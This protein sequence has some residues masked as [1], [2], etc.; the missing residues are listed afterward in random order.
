MTVFDVCFVGLKCYDLISGAP[1]Q[2]F[3]GGA[4]KQIVSLARG[5]VT[6]GHR[7]TFVTY[8]H[9]QRDADEY[10]GIRVFKS[11]EPNIGVPGVRFVHPRMTKL[12]NAM[13]R[14]NAAV[15]IQMGA[16]SETGSVAIGCNKYIGGN[17]SFIY[18]VASDMDCDPQLPQLPRLRE[19]MLYRYGLRRAVRVITQTHNQQHMMG[20]S[21]AIDSDVITMPC[22]ESHQDDYDTKPSSGANSTHVIWVGRI[23]EVKRLEWLFEIAEKCPELIFDVVGTPNTDSRYNEALRLRATGISN[24]IMHGRVSEPKLKDLYRG[25]SLLC[26][27]SR[28]E[29]FPTTFLEAWSCGIPVVTSFDP[30]G[31][32]ARHCLGSVAHNVEDMSTML[33]KLLTSPD[34][35]RTA[36]ERARRYYMEHHTVSA[37]V[38]K[39]SNVLYEANHRV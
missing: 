5:L 7:V 16:G 12:W 35:Y 36:S 18:C 24:V 22:A 30:D 33:R 23:I 15:Y 9:G 10:D 34:S 21:F 6:N 29:G 37:A 39:F 32:V 11:F 25:A 14:A 17:R 13:R 31:I 8:D 20:E 3:L 4:E 27:T 1:V 2:R 19:R 26:C 28:V 38:N